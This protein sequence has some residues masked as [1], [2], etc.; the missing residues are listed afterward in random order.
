MIRTLFCGRYTCQINGSNKLIGL[1]SGMWEKYMQEHMPTANT[2]S[3][4]LEEEF[5]C[6]TAEFDGWIMRERQGFPIAVYCKNQKALFGLQITK[7]HA[8][9]V[10]VRRALDNYLRI[11]IQYGLMLALCQEC[12]GLHGVTILCGNEMIILSASSAT[13]KTTLAK[14]L[15]KYCDVIIIN[16]DFSLLSPTEDGVF[17]EPTPF[18]GSSGRALNHRFQ[19]NRVVFLGQAK[20]NHW[21]TLDSRNALTRFLSNAFVPEW[22]SIYQQ[23]VRSNIVK[24]IGAMKINAFDFAPTQEAAEE[25]L[26][27]IEEDS[28]IR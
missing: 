14:L 28:T 24:C 27:I 4:N 1:I 20:E 2:I 11:G 15:E 8:V 10:C 16:G 21:C 17:F 6:E 9:T 18:C 22:D 26:K 7:P 23:A 13:G 19:V 12:V 3:I 5:Q 25:F